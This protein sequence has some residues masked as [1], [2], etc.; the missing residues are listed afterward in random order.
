MAA[1]TFTLFD[2]FTEYMGDGTI[3]LD[4]HTFNMTLHTST[5]TPSASA[6]LL[7][8]DLSDEL[9]TANGYTSGGQAMTSVT[10]GQTGGVATF[11][12]DPVQWTASGA[13][14]TARYA[15][16]RSTNGSGPLVGW[17]LLESAPAD[18]TATAGNT[19]TVTPNASGWFTNSKV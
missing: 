3:D 12:S 4:T 7:Y 18:V 17:I 11:D 9:S 13:G 10:W 5:Y 8:A 2:S 19:F 16:I 6:D 15:V 14:M 1:A